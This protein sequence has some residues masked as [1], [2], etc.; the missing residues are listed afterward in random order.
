MGA[1]RPRRAVA[2]SL[3]GGSVCR[4]QISDLL[5]AVLLS[6]L[7]FLSSLPLS[8]R[9]PLPAQQATQALNQ[10]HHTRAAPPT[11]HCTS[12]TAVLCRS[13]LRCLLLT[14][15]SHLLPPAQHSLL[16]SHSHLSL[17]HQPAAH[18]SSVL[19]AS[20]SPVV[21]HVA[22]A[23][24]DSY[25]EQLSDRSLRASNSSCAVRSVACWRCQGA[26]T[27]GCL[28]LRECAAD[29]GGSVAGA[30]AAVRPPLLLPGR[31]RDAGGGG[32]LRR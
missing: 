13:S 16:L 17:F 32:G 11:N 12:A 4:S 6:A 9:R 10:Q 14:S 3:E 20:L 26:H 18:C 15:R 23:T 27:G 28:S 2:V 7:A 19:R 21:C 22:F 5:S 29:C 1:D 31:C 24:V 25:V 30:G 8:L